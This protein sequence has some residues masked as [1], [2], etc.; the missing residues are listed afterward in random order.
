M[1]NTRLLRDTN[2]ISWSV[3][4]TLSSRCRDALFKP[5][6]YK[7][8]I[9]LL[10]FFFLFSDILAVWQQG[11]RALPLVLTL[12]AW[13][14]SFCS[15]QLV[16]AFIHLIEAKVKKKKK[17]SLVNTHAQGK[18]NIKKSG[19]SKTDMQCLFFMS[20]AG[21]VILLILVQLLKLA[22]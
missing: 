10:S 8:K 16:Q 13:K 7:I 4:R 18:Q 3:R 22:P 15:C 9:R 17:R 11:H 12:S 14:T 6:I 19:I 2:W 5:K 1:T 21:A 20:G